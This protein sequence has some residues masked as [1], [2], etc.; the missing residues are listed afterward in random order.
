VNCNCTAEF[1]QGTIVTLTATPGS[2]QR[3]INWSGATCD[4]S[5]NSMTIALYNDYSIEAKFSGCGGCHASSGHIMVAEERPTESV[6]NLVESKWRLYEQ[7][8]IIQII[9]PV[10]ILSWNDSID[11]EDK[12]KDPIDVQEARIFD[13]PWYGKVL[14]AVE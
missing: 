11:A 14:V 2:G 5:A 3:F 13:T 9:D 8:R 10:W 12:G 6:F 7:S 4:L 1:N